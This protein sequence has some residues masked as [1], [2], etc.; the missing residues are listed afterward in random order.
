MT[1]GRKAVRVECVVKTINN[2]GSA[3]LCEIL[4][5]NSHGSLLVTPYHP[6]R[7]ADT[8]RF[9]CDLVPAKTR[10]CEAVYSF[11][12][13]EEHVM[14]VGGVECIGLGHGFKGE[15]VQHP[16]FGTTKIV[17]DLK[18]CKGWERGLVVFSEGCMVRDEETGLVCG[19]KDEIW[20][21]A[22]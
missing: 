11:V 5:L 18:K 14:I 9:P 20:V 19:F 21:S 2:N 1:P 4:S 10:T 16:Y 13:S 7:V 6:V 3:K 8:W 22:A 15:V 12:L 17:D